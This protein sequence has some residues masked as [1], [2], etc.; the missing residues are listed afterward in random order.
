MSKTI[1]ML[2]PFQIRTVC[3]CGTLTTEPSTGPVATKDAG[4]RLTQAVR[5]RNSGECADSLR[6]C[7]IALNGLGNAGF[8]GRA[9]RKVAAFLKEKTGALTPTECCSALKLALEL[10]LSPVH[11]ANAPKEHRSREDSGL[12]L[13]MT[14]ALVKSAPQHEPIGAAM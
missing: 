8:E 7:R 5:A 11:H 3:V 13:A 6:R 1:A 9:P 2:S 10:F 12:A 14:A 4:S